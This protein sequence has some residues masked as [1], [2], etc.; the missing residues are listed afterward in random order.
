MEDYVNIP[1]KKYIYILKFFYMLD[2]CCCC[3]SFSLQWL[4]IV[5]PGSPR[6]VGS[7]AVVYVLTCPMAR[8]I[9]PG[10]NLCPLLWHADS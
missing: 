10:S 7:V 9:F 4:L 3:T 2:L 1:F 8:G 5:D 6:H